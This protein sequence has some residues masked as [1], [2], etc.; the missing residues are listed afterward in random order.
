MKLVGESPVFLAA[1]GALARMA[2]FDVPILI[3]G[4]TG[5]GKELAAR[6]VHY[7]SARGHRPFI[8]VNCGALPE[9][10][11][12]NELFGH[13]RGAYTDARES[14]PGV[15]ALAEGGTLFL[16]EIDALSAKAQVALLRFLQDQRYRPLG[17]HG[18]RRADVRIVAAANRNLEQL[19]ERGDFRSDLFFRIKILF[20]TL[21]PL[22]LRVG[23]AT[24]LAEHFLEECT[25]RFRQ[26]RKR[27]GRQMELWLETYHWPGNVREL[28]SLIVRE[29]LMTEG[30]TLGRPL[31]DDT[32]S[33]EPPATSYAAAKA[34]AVADFDR[35]FLRA[36]LTRASGNVTKAAAEA[37][38]DRRA[39][40]RLV[41]KYG[42]RSRDFRS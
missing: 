19:V 24:L 6:V 37:G 17:A 28:E 29:C 41:K 40:G 33:P 38:K 34:A 20:V 13:E 4:E 31:C 23:D 39:L 11:V 27:L 25:R 2:R 14:M 1:T 3:E 36:L 16:D 12:E 5:T 32:V 42:L 8:P 22:R 30:S 18:E 15:I 7:Q 9:A 21:P 35:R 10:L 26:P